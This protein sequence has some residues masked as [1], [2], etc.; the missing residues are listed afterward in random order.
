MFVCIFAKKKFE[1][2]P[3]HFFTDFISFC[4]SSLLL[5]KKDD[6]NW[7]EQMCQPDLPSTSRYFL[8]SN[9]A[10]YATSSTTPFHD[11]RVEN[12]TQLSQELLGAVR[13][14]QGS[15]ELDQIFPWNFQECLGKYKI[16]FFLL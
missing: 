4:R 7:H 15:V 1:P 5:F 13:S 14:S 8:S 6:L 12:Q 9:L 3:C 10:T 11:L 2:S 16:Y